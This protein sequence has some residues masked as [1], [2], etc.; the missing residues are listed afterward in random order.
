MTAVPL[1][2]LLAGGASTR[3]GGWPKGFLRLAPDRRVLDGP[4]AA[5][6]G[7]TDDV[8]VATRDG[9][10]GS[11]AALGLVE[12]HDER[13]ESGALA[14]LCTALRLGTFRRTWGVVTCPWDMPFV[15][16]PLLQALLDRLAA[17][18]ADA[19]VP[20][21]RDGPEP[22]C[23]AWSPSAARDACEALLDAG[24]RSA[25]ALLDRLRVARIDDA[26][27]RAF[28]DPA[29]LFLNVNTADDLA[30]AAARLAP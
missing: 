27:L 6:E 2:V 18:D 13:P 20:W 7:V 5:L 1:G 3:M 17:G 22:L 30:A 19:V 4:L 21:H 28:G 29:T 15:T 9:H 24:E 10:L 8:V 25:R 16:A 23:A 14:A 11:F 26:A 12:F